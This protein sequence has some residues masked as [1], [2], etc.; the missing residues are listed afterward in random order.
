M[1]IRQLMTTKFSE[2]E[3]S[4]RPAHSPMEGTDSGLRNANRLIVLCA[5]TAFFFILLIGGVIFVFSPMRGDDVNQSFLHLVNLPFHE[6]GHVVLSLFGD[7]AG[8]LGGTV[9]QIG[10]PL[11]CVIVF[12]RRDDYFGA[13][14]ALWW[15]GQNLVD[16]APY[17]FDARAGELVLL[18]GIT[19][20]DAP[21]FHDWHNLLGRL[22]CL[23]WDHTFA[24]TAK[25]MGSVVIIT[26]CLWAGLL[27][28]VAWTKTRKA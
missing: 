17:I 10:I 11:V 28:A 5:K 24:Y 18:G 27:L 19:G 12:L 26:A 21:D 1:P 8:V 25:A 2:P 4:H 7:F 9:M 22:H 6:A 23:E 15:V 13:A 14:S 20:Q 16:V 3:G